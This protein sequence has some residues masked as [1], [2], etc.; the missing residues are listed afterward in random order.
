VNYM[1]VKGNDKD[2]INGSYLVTKKFISNH[3]LRSAITEIVKI[4]N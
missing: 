2:P 3:A 4:L 1:K